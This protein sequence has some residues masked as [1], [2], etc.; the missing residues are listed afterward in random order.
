MRFKKLAVIAGVVLVAAIA[1]LAIAVH[2]Y[3]PRSLA[4]S[5]AASV[6]ADT[7]RELQFGDVKINVLPRPVS[8]FTDAASDDASARGS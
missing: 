4:L 6:K 8:A 7:G 5:L 1:A 2:L 3:D